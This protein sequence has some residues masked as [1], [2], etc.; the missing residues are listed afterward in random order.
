VS[1]DIAGAVMTELSNTIGLTA[2]NLV[3]VSRPEDAPL[4]GCFE[5]DD[6]KAAESYREYQARKI[7]ASIEIVS[8]DAVGGGMVEIEPV[9][10]TRAFH[11][12]RTNDS[13]GYESIGQIMSDEEKMERLLELAKKDAQIFKLKYGHLQKLAKIMSAID[14]AFGEGV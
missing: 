12:L 8:S 9:L 13:E 11:A 5:W 14:E 6:S 4:H 2:Q 1:A 3:N 7:I 10:P